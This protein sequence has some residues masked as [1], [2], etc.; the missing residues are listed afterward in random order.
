MSEKLGIFLSTDSKSSKRVARIL[1]NDGSAERNG[2]EIQFPNY[3]S[4]RDLHNLGNYVWIYVHQGD[5][6][7]VLAW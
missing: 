7:Q 3:M 4:T 6:I 5:L 1:W 2:K